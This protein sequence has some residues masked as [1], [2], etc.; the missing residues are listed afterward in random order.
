MLIHVCYQDVLARTNWMYM[1]MRTEKCPCSFMCVV[2][3]TQRHTGGCFT[4]TAVVHSALPQ[5]FCGFAPKP[6]ECRFEPG[7]CSFHLRSAPNTVYNF[8]QLELMVCVESKLNGMC[9]SGTANSSWIK[10]KNCPHTK[11]IKCYHSLSSTCVIL[12]HAT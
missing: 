6:V 8:C 1:K 7:G 3:V 9:D 4:Q 5:V 10:M 2:N 11:V 12:S